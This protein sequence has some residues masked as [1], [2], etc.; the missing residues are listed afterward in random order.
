MASDRID[1]NGLSKAA[2]LAALYNRAKPFGM[3][4]LHYDPAPMTE[5]EA[6]RHLEGTTND[7]GMPRRKTD[8]DYLK[9]RS[10]KVDLSG[11]TLDAWGYDRDYGQ[12]AMRAVIDGLRNAVAAQAV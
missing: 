1:I 8:F 4:M 2:V 5:A 11:D 12:G 9:G 7:I 6:A 3:G 10:M